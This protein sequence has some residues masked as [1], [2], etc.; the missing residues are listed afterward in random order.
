M[1]AF[2]VG[3]FILFE[4]MGTFKSFKF[5]SQVFVFLDFTFD[6]KLTTFALS[7]SSKASLQLT[8]L[9][10]CSNSLFPN[11]SEAL[12]GDHPEQLQYYKSY[13]VAAAPE[14]HLVLTL[15]TV[16]IQHVTS[17]CSFFL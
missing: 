4:A 7:N 6:Q 11:V 5:L 10:I 12:D 14:Y 13:Y 17:Y 2:F 9:P 1:C 15:V 8:F 16:K 3:P